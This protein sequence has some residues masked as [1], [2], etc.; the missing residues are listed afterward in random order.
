MA[1]SLVVYPIS[2]HIPHEQTVTYVTFQPTKKPP[3]ALRCAR[4]CIAWAV[5]WRLTK[6]PDVGPGP[7][8]FWSVGSQWCLLMS[9]DCC[10][11]SW[12][13]VIC[14]WFS[15]VHKFFTG[16]INN[17]VKP[18]HVGQRFWTAHLVSEQRLRSPLLQVVAVTDKLGCQNK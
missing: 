12:L 6:T 13:L 4:P 8:P 3:C 9:A 17:P 2:R 1:I 7:I 18:A 5:L 16:S 14:C 10:W 11:F 15:Y